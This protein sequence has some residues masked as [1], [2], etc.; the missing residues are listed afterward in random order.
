MFFSRKMYHNEKGCGTLK[1][2]KAFYESDNYKLVYKLL[3]NQF[4]G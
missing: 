4:V 3:I 1:L 2:K